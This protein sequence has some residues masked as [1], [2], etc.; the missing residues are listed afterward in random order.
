MSAQECGS[1][2]MINSSNTSIRD[3]PNT[4]SKCNIQRLDNISQLFRNKGTNIP[5]K[6]MTFSP[7]LTIKMLIGLAILPQG[8]VSRVS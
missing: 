4:V 7:M 5:P 3:Q 6:M 1:K 8:Q 2:T